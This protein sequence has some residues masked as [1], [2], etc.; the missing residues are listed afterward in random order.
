MGI[1]Q[2]FQKTATGFRDSW[3]PGF[4]DSG[5]PRLQYS[6]IPG[7]QRTYINKWA[8]YLINIWPKVFSFFL[9]VWAFDVNLERVYTF[10]YILYVFLLFCSKLV[11]ELRLLYPYIPPSGSCERF[12]RVTRSATVRV[13]RVSQKSVSACGDLKLC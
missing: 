6:S 3:T 4:Q 11:Y 2:G 1:L 9:W 13:T 12:T 10:F 5:I 7:F 8:V